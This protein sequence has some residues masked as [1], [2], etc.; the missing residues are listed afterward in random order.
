MTTVARCQ[1]S[2]V[3]KDASRRQGKTGDESELAAGFP[4]LTTEYQLGRQRKTGHGSE[5][6]GNTNFD[7]MKAVFMQRHK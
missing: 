7:L 1:V 6:A 5:L 3:T 2:H 4:R